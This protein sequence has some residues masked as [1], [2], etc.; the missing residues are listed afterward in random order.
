[1]ISPKVQFNQKT[2]IFILYIQ[3]INLITNVLYIASN[4][5]LFF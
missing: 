5:L 2:L 1:M 4:I 3:Y